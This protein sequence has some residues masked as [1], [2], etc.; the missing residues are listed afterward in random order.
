MYRVYIS[1]F[2]LWKTTKLKRITSLH[3]QCDRSLSSNS[4][5]IITGIEKRATEIPTVYDK[6]H[7][8]IQCY[9]FPY[10]VYISWLSRLKL[11]FLPLVTMGIMVVSYYVQ[12]GEC[13]Y[14]DLYDTYIFGG[15]IFS[16]KC[17]TSILAY[18]FVGC[19]YV[20]PSNSEVI[21]SYLDI[22]GNRVDERFEPGDLYIQ[23]RKNRV[24]Q[25]LDKIYIFLRSRKKNRTFRINLSEAEV[26]D[27][28]LFTSVFGDIPH[29]AC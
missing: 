21:L 7:G 22:I 4:R 26:I 19:I 13:T 29:S 25:Y 23:T 11:Y 9:K 24:L 15:T 5:K 10:I 1:Q 17:L 12:E 27:I 8:I 16:S 2:R 18:Q 14:E 20:N 6:Y 28:E 3:W